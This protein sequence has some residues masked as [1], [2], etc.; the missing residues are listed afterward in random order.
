MTAIPEG[1]KDILIADGVVT[2]LGPGTPGDW[3]AYLYSEPDTPDNV[4]TIYQPGNWDRASNR[5][6]LDFPIIQVRV[7]SARG[8]AQGA[9][10]KIQQVKDSLLGYDPH[11]RSGDRW[12]GILFGTDII[13]LGADENK[14]YR[15]VISFNLII[16]PAPSA[17][18]NRV[19]LNL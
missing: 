5:Y 19:P 16:E 12:A 18:T 7:R 14:R 8:D 2:G 15:F 4:V 1:I 17:L 3:R 13:P 11:D 10:T 9:M 6:L